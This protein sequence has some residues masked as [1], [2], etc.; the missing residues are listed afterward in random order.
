M[1]ERILVDP[2]DESYY[3]ALNQRRD[4]AARQVKEIFDKTTYVGFRQKINP[5]GK[6][7]EPETVV[8]QNPSDIQTPFSINSW[9]V[10]TLDMWVLIILNWQYQHT[11]ARII[12]AINNLIPNVAQ[13]KMT[14]FL[15]SL[16]HKN[17]M[18]EKFDT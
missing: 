10:S 2:S 7:G 12:T 11:S 15:V 1:S 3:D 13:K 14:L 5:D 17:A 16:L 9:I 6:L 4:R 8:Y 18:I